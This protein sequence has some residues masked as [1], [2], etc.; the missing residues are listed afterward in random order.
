MRTDI[1]KSVMTNDK[2]IVCHKNALQWSSSIN[3][4]LK[5]STTSATNSYTSV[6]TSVEAVKN[7][8]YTCWMDCM[9]IAPFQCCNHSL[10]PFT[11]SYK[12]LPCLPCKVLTA[13]HKVT[14]VDGPLDHR[15]TATKEPELM[16]RLTRAALWK[17]EHTLTSALPV[18]LVCC[19]QCS[20][21]SIKDVSSV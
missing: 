1:Y 8:T 10:L 9:D 11:H 21:H 4:L 7:G 17:P 12:R 16:K 18:S 6:S 19:F 13:Q 20:M 2:Y 3:A 14:N 15:A 5:H